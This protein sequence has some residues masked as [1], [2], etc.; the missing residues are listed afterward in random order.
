MNRVFFSSASVDWPTP[1]A[2]LEALKK[3]FGDLTDPCP[4]GGTGGLDGA[5]SRRVFV[6]PPYGPDI[7]NWLVK[8][9]NEVAVANSDLV[10][11]LLPA[12]TDTAWFHD[13]VLPYATEIRFIRR[14]LKFGG[15][16]HNA[17]FPSMVVLYA[18]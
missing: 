15:A 2:V 7:R 18:R 11:F 13:L 9:I 17:P 3:E 4:L 16:K 10:V 6:N 5:W 12:R 8:A 14:R 1:D